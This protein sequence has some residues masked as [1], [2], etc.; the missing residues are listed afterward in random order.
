M[1]T[2]GEARGMPWH[3]QF[4]PSTRD[5]LKVFDKKTRRLLAEKILERLTTDPV[6]ECRNLKTLDPNPIAQKE[7]RLLG[8][9]RI[10]LNVDEAGHMVEVVVIGEKR[11]EKLFVR[12]EEYTDHESNP[13]GGSQE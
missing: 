6:T 13:P 11:R 7:L 8:K 3:V 2:L 5:D 9:Y 10:L 1:V 12:G 4:R